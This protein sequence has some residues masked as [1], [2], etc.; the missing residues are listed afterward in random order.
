MPQMRD[1]NFA[2][3]VVLLCEHGNEGTMGLVVNRP[4]TTAVASVVRLDPP[5]DGDSDQTVWIG[6][7]VETT[8]AWILSSVDPG[9]PDRIAVGAG[10]FLGASADAL[11]L[12]LQA[13]PDTRHRFRFLLGYAGWAPGQLESELAASAWLN[14]P[15]SLDL[16]FETPAEHMWDNAIRRLGINPNALQMGPGVH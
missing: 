8:R 14:A 6:G 11:R 16:I 2:Q 4:T 15:V 10:L 12:C 3:S 1:P 9:T 13:A 7:P 5:V